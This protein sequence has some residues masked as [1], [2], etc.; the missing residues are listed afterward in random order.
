VISL[1]SNATP[2]PINT[3]RNGADSFYVSNDMEKNATYYANYSSVFYSAYFAEQIISNIEP[4][5]INKGEAS[6]YYFLMIRE[7]N[8]PC[9]L[10]ENGFH[11]NEQDRAKLL[12]DAFLDK[13]AVVYTDTIFDYFVNFSSLQKEYRPGLY[14]DVFGQL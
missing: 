5:G 7:N 3:A 6:D 9:V 13:L 14:D 10:V 8:M 12:D 11:T 4:L 1:H 2:K